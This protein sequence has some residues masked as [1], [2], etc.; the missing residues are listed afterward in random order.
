[1]MTCA[2]RREVVGIAPDCYPPRTPSPLLPHLWHGTPRLRRAACLSSHI[3]NYRLC[4]R[5]SKSCGFEPLSVVPSNHGRFAALVAAL[6]PK[7]PWWKKSPPHNATAQESKPL[8][9]VRVFRAVTAR[10]ENRLYLQPSERQTGFDRRAKQAGGAATG[11]T[12]LC[13]NGPE[14]GAGRRR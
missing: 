4:H 6:S 3:M 8:F 12:L 7:F 11:Y 10:R 14:W 13:A 1:M 2:S 9:L 5:S